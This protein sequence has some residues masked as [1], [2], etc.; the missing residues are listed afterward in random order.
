MQ[1]SQNIATVTPIFARKE[2]LSKDDTEFLCSVHDLLRHYARRRQVDIDVL[3]GL[4]ASCDDIGVLFAEGL[5]LSAE[6]LSDGDLNGYLHRALP[7]I[8]WIDYG[9]GI[10]VMQHLAELISDDETEQLVSSATA[11]IAHFG[12][13]TGST[14]KTRIHETFDRL[15]APDL[16]GDEQEI[17]HAQL[18]AR[19]LARTLNL[20]KRGVSARS[21]RLVEEIPTGPLLQALAREP[22]LTEDDRWLGSLLLRGGPNGLALAAA[23]IQ[24]APTRTLERLCTLL[25]MAPARAML[26]LATVYGLLTRVGAVDEGVLQALR[27]PLLA[28]AWQDRV[29]LSVPWWKAHRGEVLVADLLK[30]L[31][32]GAEVLARDV[33]KGLEVHL[34]N[35][36]ALYDTLTR[37]ALAQCLAWLVI[38][39]P[40]YIG[41]FRL[42]EAHLQLLSR[43][44][45]LSATRHA[46][47]AYAMLLTDTYQE[48]AKATGAE[49][50]RD[51]IA[52]RLRNLRNTH[53]VAFPALDTESKSTASDSLAHCIDTPAVARWERIVPLPIRHCLSSGLRLLGLSNREAIQ[54]GIGAEGEF[55]YRLFSKD[56]DEL[57]DASLVG[58]AVSN[59][60]VDLG[61]TK[62]NRTLGLWTAFLL[63]LT[64]SGAFIALG[65]IE[66]VP[67]LVHALGLFVVGLSVTGYLGALAIS[68]GVTS[69]SLV[70]LPGVQGGLTIYQTVHTEAARQAILLDLNA[71]ADL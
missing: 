24:H 71:G 38:R 8:W 32:P 30:E 70:A 17:E 68:R 53:K 58:G 21:L 41:P 51:A 48:V 45:G 39:Q 7:E 13:R 44:A 25:S 10:N 22:V 15:M 20:C 40:S 36:T 43:T 37:Q 57:D 49:T 55:H 67:S 2:P 46:V 27:A 1:A 12:R 59:D 3:D 34:A 66:G 47:R 4:A 9:M 31:G 50:T 52:L 42:A 62:T 26:R 54:V 18:L 65:G 35:D 11:L 56:F 61:Q 64:T 5:L 63:P 16:S 33:A 23:S 29:P 19:G 14:H 28:Q 60:L 69:G 6:K